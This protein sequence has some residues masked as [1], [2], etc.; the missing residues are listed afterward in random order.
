[1]ALA[2]AQVVDRVAAIIAA[3]PAYVGKVHTSRA[4][5]LADADLPAWRVYAESE[6]VEPTGPTFPALQSH[7]LMVAC[8]GVARATANLDD[9]INAMAASALTALFASASTARLTPLNCAMSLRRIDREMATE[10]EAAIGR[11]TLALRV[12]FHTF[13]NAPETI[14]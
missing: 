12:R 9:S 10:G 7:E 8:D 11:I 13:N 14:T 3:V 5:P 1:M 4:W 2:S 6:E